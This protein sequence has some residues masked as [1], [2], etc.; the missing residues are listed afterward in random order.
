MRERAKEL[1]REKL[2][3]AKRGQTPRSS[4]AF[5]GGFGNSSMGSSTAPTSSPIAEKLPTTPVRETQAAST[6]MKLSSRGADVDSFVSRLAK[7]GDVA[8]LAPQVTAVAKDKAPLPADHK[9]VHLRFEERLSL[10]LGRDGDIQNFELS[11]FVVPSNGS[12]QAFDDIGF[13]IVVKD[14]AMKWRTIGLFDTVNRTDDNFE[15]FAQ[16]FN[17]DE[18]EHKVVGYTVPYIY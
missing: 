16:I 9:D 5:S 4:T 2:E 1:Q 3:A 11:A 10:T 17:N 12:Q 15:W 13:I 14:N 6:A 18:I 7:E 8:A